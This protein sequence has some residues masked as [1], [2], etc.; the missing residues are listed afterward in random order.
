M[1]E[2]QV[3]LLFPCCAAVIRKVGPETAANVIQQP[4]A[5]VFKDSQFRNSPGKGVGLINK[6]FAIN[7]SGQNHSGSTVGTGHQ[8]VAILEL[9]HAGIGNVREFKHFAFKGK[10]TAIT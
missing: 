5:A 2:K 9:N 6:G 10:I 1:A 3:R 8:P 4:Y 7:A